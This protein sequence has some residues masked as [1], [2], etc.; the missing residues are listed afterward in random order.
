MQVTIEQLVDI[1][2][3]DLT[4]SG[5]LPK[6]LPDIEIER[7][8]KEKAL[9]F[10]YKNYT[11]AVQKSYYMLSREC[12]KSDEYTQKG[13]ITLPE[14]IEGISRIAFISDPSL[15]Q[16]GFQSPNLSISLGT[17]NTPYLSSFVTN[18]G[19]LGLY[20]QV[21]SYFST[22]LNK[23]A[24]NFVRHSFNHINKRLE[25]LDSITTDL[26]LEVSVRVQQENMF[27][28]YLFKDYV[29]GLSKIKVGQ[30]LGYTT[31]AMPGSFNYNAESYKSD[32]EALVAKV[33]EKVK[34]ES[35]NSAWFVMSK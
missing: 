19:E 24:K 25:I 5:M 29:I 17:T 2:Q 3:S 11:F 30:V 22:E 6:I 10:F 7:L 20:R 16:I 14:E 28:N 27:D 34:A 15:F 9:E 1:V 12:L 21:L 32:G 8:I 23:M 35:P 13:Y 33:E 4:V 26:M 31:A 18:I